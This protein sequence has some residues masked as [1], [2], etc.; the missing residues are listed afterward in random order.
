MKKIIISL[1]MIAAIAAIGIGATR[2]F[3]SD[4]VTSSGNSFAAGT[5]SLSVDSARNPLPTKFT[6][7]NLKPGDAST[8]AISYAVVNTGSTDGFLNLVGNTVVVTPGTG[9]AH[10]VTNGK[11]LGNLLNVDVKVDGISKYSG[12]LSGLTSMSNMNV[13]LAH[14]VSSTVTVEYSWTQTVDDN[15]AQGDSAL[16]GLGFNLSQTALP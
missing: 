3:F 10:V 11:S 2:A 13:A 14:G 12:I 16:V 6:I 15:S 8:T 9:V 5:L 4:T 7:A 1:S